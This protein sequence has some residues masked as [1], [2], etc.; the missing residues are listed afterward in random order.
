MKKCK[1]CNSE[2]MSHSVRELC[3]KCYQKE[4]RAKKFPKKP[5][6]THC[7]DCLIDLN[8]AKRVVKG[9]CIKC[10][11]KRIVES[12]KK[13]CKGCGLVLTIGSATGFCQ[14]CRRIHQPNSYKLYQERRKLK[15]IQSIEIT[16]DLLDEIKIVLIKFK[17]GF[18]CEIDVY[19]L[20][21]IHLDTC[22]FK[23]EYEAQ[24]IEYQIYWM[25][26]DIKKLYDLW[27]D[28]SFV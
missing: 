4:W 19:R 28:R 1:V 13:P 17:R 27:K 25:L 26:K 8:T 22:G 9:L 23:N 3:Q 16:K 12:R 14:S 18:V 2:K 10:Y 7:I 6:A 24:S 21:N 11:D 15:A 5:K 20:V